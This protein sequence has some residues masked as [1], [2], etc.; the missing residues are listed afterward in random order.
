MVSLNIF[1]WDPVCDFATVKYKEGRG[2][3]FICTCCSPTPSVLGTGAYGIVNICTV[4]KTGT[5]C[6]LFD[7]LLRIHSGCKCAMKKFSF[8]EGLAEEKQQTLLKSFMNELNLMKKLRHKN[9]I[10]VLGFTF[11]DIRY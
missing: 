9:I 6:M 3:A 2:R 4:V 1:R 5:K 11:V 10:R 7:D 8:P